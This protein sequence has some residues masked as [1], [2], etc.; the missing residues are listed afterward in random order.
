MKILHTSDWHLGHQ[1]HSRRRETEFEQFLNWLLETIRERRIDALIVAGDLFDSSAPSN[2]AMRLYCDFLL[3]LQ[4]TPCRLA[5]LTGGNHDSPSFLNAPRELLKAAFPIEIFGG[6]A[7]PE[8]ELVVLRDRNGDPELIVGAV[9]VSARRRS[10]DALLRGSDCGTGEKTG[11]GNA[12]TL[13]GCRGRSGGAARGTGDSG[14][15]HRP[16]VFSRRENRFRR[17][18]AGIH[19]RNRSV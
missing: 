16:S 9:P 11:G 10:D 15:P 5:V 19:R 18:D 8:Q 14:C 17:R 7:K 4:S 6:A 2:A 3:E 13:P 1:F 12:G